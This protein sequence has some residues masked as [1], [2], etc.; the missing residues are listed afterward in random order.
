MLNENINF[1]PENKKQKNFYITI[2]H[3]FKRYFI[4]V[5]IFVYLPKKPK[6]IINIKKKKKEKKNV[7]WD[8]IVVFVHGE[9][10]VWLDIG[11][12]HAS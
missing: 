11:Y 5:C 9:L 7:G 1:F 2:L 6:H 12:T 10:I 8:L 4:S 3:T